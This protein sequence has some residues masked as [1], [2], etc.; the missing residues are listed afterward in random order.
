MPGKF[1][2]QVLLDILASVIC[3][4]RIPL[5]VKIEVP[6]KERV[7]KMKM[8]KKLL[9]VLL[10]IACVTL[11]SSCEVLE[12]FHKHEY[13]DKWSYNEDSHWK[14]CKGDGCD[15]KTAEADHSFGEPVVTEPKDGKDGSKVY[16]CTVCSKTKTEVIEAPEHTHTASDEWISDSEKHWHSCEGKDCSSKLDASSH[17]WDE[18]TVV[19]EALSGVEGLIRYTCLVCSNTKSEAI[20]AL[21]E[22]MSE[23]DWFVLFMIENA[24]IDCV[25]GIEGYGSSTTTVYIDGELAEVVSD[26]FSYYSDSAT[27]LAV[28]D[29]SFNYD[30][31]NHLGDGVYYAKSVVVY[32]EESEMEVS[33]VIMVVENDVISVI[34]YSVEILGMTCDVEFTFSEWGEVTVEMPTLTEEE[35][36]AALDH[37]NFHNYTLDTYSFDENFSL[38]GTTYY[39]DGDNCYFITYTDEEYEEGSLTIENAG[40]V[41]NEYLEALEV[42]SASD[43]VYNPDN[44]MY[45]YYEITDDG[46]YILSIFIE[47][48]VLISVVETYPDGTEYY[49]DLYD[50]GVTTVE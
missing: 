30:D 28:L 4:T 15:A 32:D 12:K 25:S 50:H 23:D 45:S 39:F 10:V 46:E 44:A 35:Y 40:V 34:T 20:P 14:A 29:F 1:D 16:T 2:V 43:F 31:F 3:L 36:L 27:E 33:D 17:V 48:G 13:S 49:S 8:T 24:R 47:E 37:D 6:L 22:K 9:L 21:P 42:L 11:A 19:S 41:M 5:F 26:D 38:I 18:G 7:T